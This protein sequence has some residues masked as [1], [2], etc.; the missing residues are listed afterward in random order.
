MKIRDQIDAKKKADADEAAKKAA[1]EQADSDYVASQ[2]AAGAADQTLKVSLAKTGPVY[3]SDEQGVEVWA[4]DPRVLGFHAFR[5]KSG[6]TEVDD[7]AE[8]AP[9][10]TPGPPPAPTPDPEPAPDPDPEPAPDPD[11]E[12]APDPG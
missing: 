6:D 8:P 5:P 1:A 3:V 9:G 2:G 4:P 7:D 10:P 11:P 12:P